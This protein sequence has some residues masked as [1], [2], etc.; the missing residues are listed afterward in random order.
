MFQKFFEEGLIENFFYS[1]NVQK[2]QIAVNLSKYYNTNILK[3][4]YFYI[5]ILHEE[6]NCN[7]KSLEYFDRCIKKY[8]LQNI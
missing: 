2:M 4:I 5:K 3:N 1:G 8:V 7:K 6:S